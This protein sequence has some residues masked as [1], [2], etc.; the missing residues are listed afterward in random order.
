MMARPTED[1]I[2]TYMSITGA[3]RSLALQKL[4][5]QC[6]S[7]SLSLVLHFL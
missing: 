7:L 2:E 4:E 6:Y 5:V 3:S 1:M